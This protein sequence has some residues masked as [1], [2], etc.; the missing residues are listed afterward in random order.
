MK[1][2]YSVSG[3][4]CASCANLIEKK[5]S[6]IEGIHEVH[7][8][9]ATKQAIVESEKPVELTELNTPIEDYWYSLSSNSQISHTDHLDHRDPHDLSRGNLIALSIMIVIVF[10]MMFFETGV[11][12]NWWAANETVRVFLHHLMPIFA[13]YVLFWLGMRYIRAAFLYF[14]YMTGNMET[15]IGIGSLVA[16]LYSFIVTAFEKVLWPIMDV[17]WNFYEGIIVVVG[18]SLI[19]KYIETH[20]LAKTGEAIASLIRL[21]AKD[22]LVIREWTEIRLSL[23]DIRRWDHILVKPGERVPV[24]GLIRDGKTEIDE[25]MLTGESLPVTKWA[26]DSVIGGTLNINGAVTLEATTLGSESVLAKIVSLV[27]EAQNYKPSIQKLADTIAWYFVPVVLCLALLTLWGWIVF[28]DALVVDPWIRGI[29]GF[30]AILAVACPCALGLATPLAIINSIARATRHGILVKNSEWLLILKD[31]DTIIFDKTGTLTTGMP[32]LVWYDESTKEDLSILYSL[33]KLSH[34]PI[35]R[36]IVKS[37]EKKNIRSEKVTD[38]LNLPWK[39]IAGKIWEKKYYVGNALFAR[40]I[41]WDTFT[42]HTTSSET[43]LFLFTDDRLLDMYEVTDT[44]KWGIEPMIATL[45]ER[46]IELI[47]STGDHDAVA[48][49]IAKKVGIETVYSESNPEAKSDLIASLQKAGKKVAM[50]WD[51]VND[52]IALSRADVSISFSDGSDVSI[53]SSDLVLLGGDLT[54]FIDAFDISK[55]M[56]RLIHEN[57]FWA[58]SYNIIGIPLAG[59]WLYPWLGWQLTPVFT[60]IFMAL[61]SLIVTVNSMRGR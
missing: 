4:T 16:F 29:I 32:T 23:S 12:Y 57:L 18:F 54:K 59:G 14:R 13:T 49:T 36:G 6:K 19:G 58:F 9:L 43:E 48:H 55:R 52:S 15:L 26:G 24:D 20:A 3:M 30:V 8:N 42:T 41:L 45:K 1:T 33:E 5:L 34:H 51:G 11:K 50:I 56:N 7:V 37:L 61:S 2:T 47:L 46:G 22:A 31:I 38:F 35:A 40:E 28:W 60:G 27:S 44:L 39:G 17:S 21:E 53:E 25:S 10:I